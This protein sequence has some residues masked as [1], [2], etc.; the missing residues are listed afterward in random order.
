ME[1]NF[2]LSKVWIFLTSKNI[3]QQPMEIYFL[4]EIV[5]FVDKD[6]DPLIKYLEDIYSLH[7]FVWNSVMLYF[8]TFVCVSYNA[9]GVLS[10]FWWEV[11][12]S[13]SVFEWWQHSG[14]VCSYVTTVDTR[15]WL[16]CYSVWVINALWIRKFVGK[17]TR[18]CGKKLQCLFSIKCLGT[19]GET[20][21]NYK[22]IIL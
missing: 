6:C 2:C 21:K 16:Q 11:S 19:Y 3:S 9:G 22:L 7:M 10:I 17:I 4:S 5:H 12:G 15:T 8:N 20:R 1:I 14:C 13:C 18:T